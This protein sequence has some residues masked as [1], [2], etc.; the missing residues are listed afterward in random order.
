MRFP[1][2]IGVVFIHMSP[3]T[4]APLSGTIPFWSSRSLVNLVEIFFSHALTAVCVPAFFFISGLLFFINCNEWNRKHYMTKLK[5]RS[6]TLL[7]P[8][9]LWCIIAF[10]PI[11]CMNLISII[12][13]DYQLSNFLSYVKNN[14]FHIFYDYS[15]MPSTTNIIGWSILNDAPILLP[16]WFLRDLIILVLSTPIIRAGLKNFGPSFI[17]LLFICYL[18]KIWIPIPGFGISG[19]FWFSAGAYISIHKTDFIGFLFR[20]RILIIS[21]G[22]ASFI[23]MTIID[24]GNIQYGYIFKPCL[25]IPCIC[26]TF[27]FF[28]AIAKIKDTAIARSLNGACF[29]IYALHVFVIPYVGTPLSIV[30]RGLGL[31]IGDESG[32]ARICIHLTAPLITTALCVILYFVLNKIMPRTTAILS[33][34]R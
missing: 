14:F 25:L 6:R 10:I 8:F 3:I 27:Y 1:L 26:L 30:R 32:L 5:S 16:L 21:S 7:L 18:T 15:G 13:H 17:A 28:A 34:S 33:G 29:F 23:G 12:I 9:V 4:T 24:G 22:I 20:N 2:A 19:F 11:L 31:A